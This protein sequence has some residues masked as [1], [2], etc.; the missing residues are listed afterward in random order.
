MT[1]TA[2]KSP[3]PPLTEVSAGHWQFSLRGLLLTTTAVAG[4]L[5]IG[6]ATS[7]SV[8]TL[9][10][11]LGLTGLNCLGKLEPFRRSNS[12]RRGLFGTSWALFGLSLFLPVGQF[13]CN[14]TEQ[15]GYQTVLMGAQSE[16][17]IAENIVEKGLSD[18]WT[19]DL[20]VIQMIS[21][22]NLANL[23][24]LLSPLLLWRLQQGKGEWYSA[25]WLWALTSLPVIAID[26]PKLR[27]GY[28]CW[29]CSQFLVVCAF[30]IKRWGWAIFATYA[31]A[32]FMLGYLLR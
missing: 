8:A 32:N 24:L 14:G 9:M 12:S 27:L 31:I 6:L 7:P 28:Y 5:G 20:F 3:D 2:G 16:V 30:P 19:K 21:Q 29:T 10:V 22:L 25:L 18:D 13:G 11:L 26:L 4:I 17:M 15:W 1:T 23:L